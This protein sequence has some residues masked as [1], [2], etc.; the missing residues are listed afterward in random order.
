ML[1]AIEPQNR[2][3]EEII[4]LIGKIPLGKEKAM[5]F[6]PSWREKAIWK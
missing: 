2:F 5:G 3:R 4:Q 1:D 6:I